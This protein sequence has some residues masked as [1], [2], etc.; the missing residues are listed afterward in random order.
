MLQYKISDKKTILHVG[1][2]CE[3]RGNKFS[4]NNGVICCHQVSWWWYR[5]GWVIQ[6]PTVTTATRF[7]CTGPQSM[8]VC[9]IRPSHQNK[10]KSNWTCQLVSR[11]LFRRQTNCSFVRL[12]SSFVLPSSCTLFPSPLFQQTWPSVPRRHIY[13]QEQNDWGR[14]ERNG[15]RE[16]KWKRICRNRNKEEGKDHYRTWN[17]VETLGGGVLIKTKK[18]KKNKIATQFSSNSNKM[19]GGKGSLRMREGVE[20]LSSELTRH[21]TF[22]LLVHERNEKEI[23]SIVSARWKFSPPS[24]TN[25]GVGKKRRIQVCHFLHLSSCFMLM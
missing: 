5:A 20:A 22:K 4:A 2:C 17:E 3:S 14:E 23:T 8:A 25:F 10:G 13:I 9:N 7:A 15:M 12:V 21:S 1:R 16:S 11:L 18:K 6:C 19:N 24:F